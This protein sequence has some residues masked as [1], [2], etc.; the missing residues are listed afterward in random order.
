MQKSEILQELNIALN[1]L[2][3]NEGSLQTVLEQHP[4]LIPLPHLLNHHHHFNLMFKKFPL[5]NAQE[6]DFLYLTKSTVEWWVVLIEIESSNKKIFTK[7]S[8]GNVVFHSDFNNSYDQIIS[9]KA[10]LEQNQEPMKEAILPLLAHMHRNTLNFKYVLIIGR[11]SDIITQAQKNMF[12][13]K[14]TNEIK[15]MTY[16]SLIN[17][18]NCQR[19]SKKIIA[20]KTT[21]GYRL[22]HLNDADTGLFS[23]LQRGEILFDNEIR[24]QLLDKG[25][26]ISAWENGEL[27]T[28]NDKEPS[29]NILKIFRES[30]NT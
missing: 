9:W 11:N 8:N 12:R 26:N 21:N 29:K 22:L 30:F 20:N 13:Q 7:R 4:E 23:L 24:Q 2:G 27:L 25:Y 15:V 5:P 17:Y 16:D 14:N 1:Q 3:N 18:F 28:I 19:L 10:Y 6:T